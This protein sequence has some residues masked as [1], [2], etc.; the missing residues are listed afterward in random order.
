MGFTYA[1]AAATPAA[2]S[3][4]ARERWPLMLSPKPDKKTDLQTSPPIMIPDKEWN[5]GFL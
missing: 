2:E 3:P 1:A 5:L 4:A